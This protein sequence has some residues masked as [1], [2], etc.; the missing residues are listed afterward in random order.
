MIVISKTKGVKHVKKTWAIA[1]SAALSLTLVGCGA[2]DDTAMNNNN[3]NNQGQGFNTEQVRTR[4]VNNNNN[5]NQTNDRNLSVSDRAEL[6]VERMN[7]V[8]EANV[9]IWNNNAYVAVRL[10]NQDDNRNNRNGGMN[11]SDVNNGGDNNGNAVDRTL[12]N[13]GNAL[14][15]GTV[16]QSDNRNG[17]NGMID[18]QGDAGK[19][20]QQ[21][22][23]NNN[24]L[25]DVNNN[26]NN[27]NNNNEQSGAT[28][29]HVTTD[30]AS[31]WNNYSPVSNAFEQKIADRV[32]QAENKIH[33][34]YVSN[35]PDLYGKMSTYADELRTNG[36]GNGILDDFNNTVNNFFGRD[37]E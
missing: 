18:G 33:K 12:D 4:N 30:Y 24:N 19:G 9:I 28:P 27:N 37:N 5:N 6:Q 17:N 35:N 14:N 34:V 23:G 32:R 20:S 26:N 31:N 7:E 36:N 22:T 11:A 1:A 21:N 25:F 15:N 2:N 29:D 16:N 3:N 8:E 13:G 10:A